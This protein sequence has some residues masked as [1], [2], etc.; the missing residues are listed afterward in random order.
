MANIRVDSPIALFDGQPLSFKSPAN[1]SNVTGLRVY[2]PYG[3]TTASK[4]FQFADAHGNNVGGLNLFAANVVVKV[5]LDT[6]DSLAFVQNADTNAY[7]ED[8]FNGKSDTGH[9]HTKAEITDFPTSMPASDV[10]SWAKASSKPKYTASEVGA[11][12]TTTYTA[13][14]T[15][16]WTASGEHFYQDVTVSGILATDNPMVDINAGSDNAANA[17]YSEAICKVFRITTSANKIRVWATENVTTAFPI[18][19]KVVR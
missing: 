13:T 16:T 10:P 11:A 3:D 1:C 9:K 8:R 14:V 18:Q 6:T 4:A 2:Y 12:T 7:L 17:L 19:L 5:I 15:T